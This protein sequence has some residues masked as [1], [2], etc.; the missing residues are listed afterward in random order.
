MQLRGWSAASAAGA[1]A[2]LHTPIV[3]VNEGKN[4]GTYVVKELVYSFAMWVIPA[5][6][7]KVVRAYDAL[8]TNTTICH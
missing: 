8:V 1:C 5:F 2:D 4:N 6:H 3:T 7:P